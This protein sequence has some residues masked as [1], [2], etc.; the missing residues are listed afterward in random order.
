MEYSVGKHARGMEGL[1]LGTKA[2]FG[3]L[4]AAAKQPSLRLS[5]KLIEGSGSIAI[6]PGERMIQTIRIPELH[7]E[8]STKKNK[9]LLH[10][11]R[12]N[13]PQHTRCGSVG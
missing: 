10:V 2:N 3:S 8:P 6:G 1:S 12:I 11:C 5:R 7:V 4:R 9:V 13:K